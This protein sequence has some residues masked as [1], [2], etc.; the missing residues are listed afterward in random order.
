MTESKGNNVENEPTPRRGLWGLMS[1]SKADSD[2]KI[3][4]QPDETAAVENS[5]DLESPVD[6]TETTQGPTGLWAVMGRKKAVEDDDSD[7]LSPQD[8]DV[9]EE[10][11]NELE[12]SED[13]APTDPDP[14]A[15]V[16]P[17]GGLWALMG[18]SDSPAAPTADSE[19]VNSESARDS[20]DEPKA[21]KGLW[22]TMQPAAEATS[23]DDG[24]QPSAN[25]SGESGVKD[26]TSAA[27]NEPDKGL[28]A[29]MNRSGGAADEQ[30]APPRDSESESPNES[31]SSVTF[32]SSDL[33]ELLADGPDELAP[34]DEFDDEEFAADESPSPHENDIAAKDSQ[35]DLRGHDSPASPPPISAPAAQP[36][37][38]STAPAAPR[39]PIVGARGGA[40]NV[41][42]VQRK[43]RRNA[44]FSLLFG[45]ISV[46]AG[47]L[48]LLPD[49]W[50]KFPSG[51]AG[52]IAL[53]LGFL[54]FS[55]ARRTK[56]RGAVLSSMGMLLGVVGMLAGPLVFSGIGA[57]YRQK[58]GRENTL[59][60]LQAV[61]TA[62]RRYHT[63]YD[64][65][66]MAGVIS[67]NES[68]DD[69]PMH[70]WQTA[71]L[72]FLGEENDAVY[73]KIRFSQPYD[74]I[75]NAGPMGTEITEFYAA[76]GNRARIVTKRTGQ[77]EIKL[78]VT[79]FAGIGG[80]MQDGDGGLV[81]LGVFGLNRRISRSDILDGLG[82]TFV[83]GEINSHFPAWGAPNNFRKIEKGLNLDYRGFG[84][85]E[86]TGAMMLKA[87]GSV[88]FFSKSTSIDILKQLSTRDGN[89][90]VP[91]GF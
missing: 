18:R 43:V 67:T 16:G 59:Q 5:G 87:D 10:G 31:T 69:V 58:W 39:S 25:L 48:T 71:L 90:Y 65:Y 73:R 29:M 20:T 57:K 44:I 30:V 42:R 28:W 80:E 70:G 88:K 37:R 33:E 79:H 62:M 23:E 50:A 84:N 26:S 89:E 1:G 51:V 60:N 19:C 13:S 24:A 78:A 63:R 75:V 35:S 14:P 64:W 11:E 53:T 2:P 22:A 41:L 17:Q 83:G 54:A 34:D 40:F 66:P 45:L 55:E 21:G 15:R 68:G 12:T 3:E 32:G 7:E 82:Q 46:P 86:G 52:F 85:A 56:G 4:Q 47:A 77:P 74:S 61:G 36:P 8:V 6:A 72:P 9:A 27:T 49:W 81:Q 91:D 38:L 76:G